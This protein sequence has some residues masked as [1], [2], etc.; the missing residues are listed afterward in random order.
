MS[1]D[2]FSNS[3]NAINLSK[4]FTSHQCRDVELN[5]SDI[6]STAGAALKENPIERQISGAND[7][8]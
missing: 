5:P 2:I 6:L 4:G 1:V 8:A 7:D 3:N